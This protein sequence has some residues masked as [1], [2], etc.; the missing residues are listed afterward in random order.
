MEPRPTELDDFPRLTLDNLGNG[1]ARELF[2]AELERVVENL[3]DPNANPDSKRSVTLTATFL[4]GKE[5]NEV[6]VLVEV[7]SKIAPPL[8]CAGTAFVGRRNGKPVATT[9]NA[10][11]LAL[12]FDAPVAPLASSSPESGDETRKAASK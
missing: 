3:L 7:S 9:Y 1:A 2:A 11:Q 10:R 6:G 4:P 5:R 8:G 12:A